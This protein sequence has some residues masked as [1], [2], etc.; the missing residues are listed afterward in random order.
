MILQ[1]VSK[2]GAIFVIPWLLWVCKAVASRDTHY[3]S[4]T[5]ITSG[6]WGGLVTGRERMSDHAG[7]L[8]PKRE[9]EK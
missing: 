1:N 3:L 7:V 2:D 8:A 9:E 6:P 5:M 4:G